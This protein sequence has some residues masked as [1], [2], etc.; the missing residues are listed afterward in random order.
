LEVQK[1]EEVYKDALEIW[2]INHQI[3]LLSEECGEVITALN[4]LKRGRINTESLLEEFADVDVVSDQ[5]IQ[6]YGKEKIDPC[7]QNSRILD[8][9]TKYLEHT[10]ESTA[11]INLLVH[12]CA[13]YVVAMDDFFYLGK[14]QEFFQAVANMKLVLGKINKEFSTVSD[15]KEYK[16][17]RLEKR[18]QQKRN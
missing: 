14:E 16:L 8:Y 3:L 15:H 13:S 11:W 4:H 6:Y 17:L 12:C 1:R 5:L 18:I 9:H 10:D 7:L 2:G